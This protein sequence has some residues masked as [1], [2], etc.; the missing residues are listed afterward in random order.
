MGSLKAILGN[1]MI[2]QT[3][4]NVKSIKVDGTA[5]IGEAIFKTITVRQENGETYQ[6]TFFAD[7][8]AKLEIEE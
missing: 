8:V 4:H 7:D 6:I 2:T 1:D 3:V 5:V